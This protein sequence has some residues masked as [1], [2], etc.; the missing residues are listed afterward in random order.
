[1]SVPIYPHAKKMFLKI[2][3]EA[4]TL[5]TVLQRGKQDMDDREWEQYGDAMDKM[6]SMLYQLDSD[7]LKLYEKG[8]R[9]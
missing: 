5:A 7:L 8:I 1:M 6:I 3:H 2:E 9:A 4:R